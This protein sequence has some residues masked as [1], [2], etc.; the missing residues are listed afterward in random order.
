MASKARTYDVVLWG[1]TGF[2]GKL[3]A[4]YLHKTYPTLRWAIAGRS[5]SALQ[6]MK[7]KLGLNVEVLTA[8]L[9]DPQSLQKLTEST[10]VILST[11]GP[12]AKIGTP[13]VEACINGGAHYCDL[14]GEAQWVREMV[15]TYFEQAAA[16]KVKIV[17]CCG[18]DCI[19]CDLGTQMVLD[20]ALALGLAPTE[21]RVR[22]AAD[23]SKGGVSGGTIASVFNILESLPLSELMK[24]ANPFYLNPRNSQG[25]IDAC[26]NMMPGY[27][28]VAKK[29]T[30]PYFMQGIDLRLVNRSHALNGFKYGRD[31]VFSERMLLPNLPMAVIGSAVMALVQLMFLLP[32]TRFF[33]KKVL[34][35]PG[36]GPDQDKLDNGF[37][38][39]LLYAKGV[40]A[41][42]KTEVVSGTVRAFGGDP[43][44]RQ[45]A[46]MIGES[47]VC[48]ALDS[49]LPPAYGVL[50]P[51]VAMGPALR[52]RLTKQGIEFKLT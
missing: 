30:M 28:D 42:G 9:K 40:N 43:G 48:L 10:K 7:L 11:A 31:L 38:T 19:P 1:A 23:K 25:A 6:E 35:S 8:D 26:D 24:L 46:K 27:D 18:Y 4:E 41:A 45:T 5:A 14:T 2:T 36:E 34:P 13:M 16:K 52:D 50:T 12:F 33:L 15:D 22:F 47:A 44:Y 20:R 29:Y 51:S 21:V 32:F 3:T 39:A 49:D 17:N 37:F